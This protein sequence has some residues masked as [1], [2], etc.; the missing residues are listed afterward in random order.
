MA[1]G[2]G[3]FEIGVS[4]I[5]TDP[6]DIVGTSDNILAR[7][8]NLLPPSWFPDDAPNLAAVLQGFANIGAFAYAMVAF[9]KL[10]TRIS[11]ASGFFLDLIAFDY[12]GRLIR[13]R[14][15]ELDATFA[16]RIKKEL[17]RERVTRL[18]MV[19]AL[20]DLTGKAPIVFEPWNTSDA[21]GYG[22]HC[23]YGVAG[24]W[25]STLLPAQ[26]FLTVYRSGQGVPGV[27]GYGGGLGGYGQ[28]AIEYVGPTMLTGAVSDQD[29]YDTIEAAKPTG[30]ICWTKLI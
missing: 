28:G 7:T 23:G 10:Q 8:R 15:G 6:V 25:G 27:D 22:T 30:V 17:I 16:A 12:F 1:D 3:D 29:I 4:A 9:A 5:E 20:T 24:G 13:R 19:Q 21:G 2:I 14:I 11:S 18:G 26:V